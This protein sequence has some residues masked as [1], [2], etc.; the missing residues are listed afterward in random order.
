MLGVKNCDSVRNA[1]HRRNATESAGEF[2][3]RKSGVPSPNVSA[4]LGVSCTSRSRT[5]LPAV[6]CNR[7]PPARTPA[8]RSTLATPLSVSTASIRRRVGSNEATF[9]EF[10]WRF[11]PC[12]CNK[13]VEVPS[14]SICVGTI[15]IAT[16]DEWDLHACATASKQTHT[17]AD[18][19]GLGP[20]R[21][22]RE[23]LAWRDCSASDAVGQLNVK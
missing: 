18:T 23:F 15:E 1:I 6:I 7:A 19:S 11:E 3:R 5:D 21:K 4:V 12:T 8:R 9:S 14:A 22:I 13:A 17:T 2:N 16:C 10:N 20:W